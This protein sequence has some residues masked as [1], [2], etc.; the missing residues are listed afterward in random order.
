M[1]E[2]DGGKSR[3]IIDNVQAD[4]A[5]REAKKRKGTRVLFKIN[6]GSRK[7]LTRLFNEYTDE[8]YKFSKT[9]VFV[10]LYEKGVD[11]VSRSQARRL[12]YGLEKFK[13]IILDFNKIK[14][15]GQGFAD[16]VFRIYRLE[17][18]KTEIIPKNASKTVMFM[19][20]RSSS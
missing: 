11:Y 4:F 3:L 2:L 13:T 19:I 14:G 9:K 8:E 16:E 18:P 17:N 1:F 10:R 20:N 12:L 15:I 5:V 7:S 6:S